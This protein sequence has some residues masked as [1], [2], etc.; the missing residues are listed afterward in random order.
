VLGK[1]WIFEV[2]EL[3][4]DFS[5]ARDLFLNIFQILDGTEKNR[6][7]RVNFGKPEGSECKISKIWTA[8]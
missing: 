5:E 8:G 2:L 7:P 4:V 3:F 1:I 6:G